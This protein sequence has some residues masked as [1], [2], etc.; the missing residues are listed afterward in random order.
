MTVISAH[1]RLKQKNHES[2]DSPDSFVLSRPG[3]LVRLCLRKQ[4]KYL[5]KTKLKIHL[6]GG[7]LSSMYKTLGSDLSITNEN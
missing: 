7:E 2:E 5:T 1:G 3:N 4:T 6:S